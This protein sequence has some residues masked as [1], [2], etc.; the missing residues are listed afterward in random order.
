MSHDIALSCDLQKRGGNSF[1]DEIDDTDVSQGISKLSD[2]KRLAQKYVRIR[3]PSPFVLRN[4]HPSSGFRPK[5]APS[6]A[7]SENDLRIVDIPIRDDDGTE[8]SHCI[9]S[10][11]E[12]SKNTH[13]KFKQNHPQHK[14]SDA[15]LNTCQNNHIGSQ[16]VSMPNLAGTS[17]LGTMSSISNR[18]RNYSSTSASSKESSVSP[19][20]E[21]DSDTATKIH[22]ATDK[23][24]IVNN[25]HEFAGAHAVI[26]ARDVD[27]NSKL[28]VMDIDSETL[29]S[30][31]S[32]V[33]L[34]QCDITKKKGMY[35]PSVTSPRVKEKRLKI[36]NILKNK[37]GAFSP[38][39]EGANE[40]P[41]IE[42]RNIV[43]RIYAKD[44]GVPSAYEN[45]GKRTE[46]GSSL[47]SGRST[48]AERKSVDNNSDDLSH[49]DY[50]TNPS[51]EVHDGRLT[52]YDVAKT[53][54]LDTESV[55]N[56]ITGGNS[57]TVT[58]RPVVL[59]RNSDNLDQCVN[60]VLNSDTAGLTVRPVSP[61][62]AQPP[63]KPARTKKK[64]KTPPTELNLPPFKIEKNGPEL[65]QQPSSSNVPSGNELNH[66]QS[67]SQSGYLSTSS[68]KEGSFL[69]F[70]FILFL[71]RIL[72]VVLLYQPFNL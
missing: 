1:H 21:S 47:K 37:K 16:F 10:S 44:R 34:T 57:D 23:G 52:P 42:E 39:S 2:E 5:S 54:S 40:G 48:D 50:S 53:N 27:Y 35:K 55:D 46:D 9:P 61:M 65:R 67:S 6:F 69:C 72:T 14:S 43:N 17:E 11:I 29:D 20:S 62:K 45:W 66:S 63:K 36:R 41:N 13:H 60:N 31:E 49:S 71:I 51:R 32:N 25:E 24:D 12:T 18:Q 33:V 56:F 8:T 15:D 28:K 70:I 26:H 3:T 19:L 64:N 68:E 7:R 30:A 58:A 4:R 38:S 22:V 59:D